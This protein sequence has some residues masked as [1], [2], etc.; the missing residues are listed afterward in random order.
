M[1]RPAPTH[2]LLAAAAIL[3]GV[4]CVPAV[5]P[6][7]DGG[8]RSYLDLAR[9]HESTW[10]CTLSPSTSSAIGY[11][12]MTLAALRDI[13][14]KDEPGQLDR[15]RMGH[16][17]GRGVPVQPPRERRGDEALYGDQLVDTWNGDVKERIGNSAYGVLIDAAS[18][19][20]GAHFLGARGM[21]EFILCGMHVTC[22]AESAVQTNGGDGAA[23]HRRLIA[24][25]KEAAGPER[26]GAD[27]RLLTP[28]PDTR[29]SR[30]RPRPGITRA[31]HRIHQVPPPA[32]RIAPDRPESLPS[33]RGR[34]ADRRL[35]REP[36]RG[37]RAGRRNPPGSRRAAR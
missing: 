33:G 19:L 8:V 18:L 31:R 15:E 36:A 3:A 2:R 35:S 10:G 16:H 6:A 27:R 21:N 5:V 17:L 34:N 11:Y 13:K 1:L 14:L 9:K 24:R 7:S 29:R 26:L 22:I 25:M 37:V 23:I 20:A 30:P 4:L 12:Q 32:P 28:S